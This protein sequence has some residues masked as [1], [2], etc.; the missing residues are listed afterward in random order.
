MRVEDY[1]SFDLYNQGCSEERTRKLI[2]L[3]RQNYLPEDKGFFSD[4]FYEVA[5]DDL[6]L[7]VMTLRAL[8]RTVGE[9]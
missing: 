8:N 6:A 7:V 1:V 4:P 2:A 3:F 9:I 5:E